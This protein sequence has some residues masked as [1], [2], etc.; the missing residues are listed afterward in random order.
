MSKCA[1]ERTEPYA[2]LQASERRFRELVETACDFLWEVDAQGHYTYCSP[3]VRTILGY[4][5]SELIGKTPFDLMLPEEAPRIREQFLQAVAGK[6]SLRTIENTNLHK[7]G[8]QVVLE[9][10]GEPFFDS[11]GAL[12]GYRGID[13]DITQKRESQRQLTVKALRQQQVERALRQSQQMLQ[14]VLDTIPVGVFWKDRQ[15]RFLGCNEV[16][17][18]DAGLARPQDIVN[19]QQ[20]DLSPENAQQY[21]DEDLTVIQSG[22]A[23]LNYEELF[24][25]PSGKKV[26]L[27]LSKIPLR[28]G[29]GNIMGVLGIYEDITQAKL[30]IDA[31]RDSEYRY[32]MAQRAARIGSWDWNAVTGQLVWSEQIEPMFGFAPGQFGRTYE[33][34]LQSVHPEDRPRVEEAVHQS[35]E[36]GT[37]YAVEHRIVWPDGTVRWVSE[38]GEVERG[39][40]GRP[41]RMLGIVQDITDRK[42]AEK[43]LQEVLI[44]PYPRRM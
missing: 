31:L 41:V 14:S 37:P 3:A 26:W 36:N 4:E 7:D 13:R 25:T 28:D 32:A 9:T 40:D 20:E 17:A 2:A 34:F 42:L 27:R 24:T 19:V 18:H 8:R 1:N 43:T 35:V 44:I 21:R 15:G 16:V 38:A 6:Q 30:A 39:D 11:D 5:P 23:K 33:A 12:G 10:S 29:D 22:Q